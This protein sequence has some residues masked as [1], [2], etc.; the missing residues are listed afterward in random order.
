MDDSSS[1][2]SRSQLSSHREVKYRKGGL[3][4]KDDLDTEEDESL[5]FN[6]I[7]AMSNDGTDG[8]NEQNYGKHTAATSDYEEECGVLE[9][10]GD[11]KMSIMKKKRPL[12]P[13]KKEGLPEET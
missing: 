11:Y 12:L 9:D 10:G 2:N 7:P 3:P 6:S 4:V 8:M 5:C 1:S 13:M